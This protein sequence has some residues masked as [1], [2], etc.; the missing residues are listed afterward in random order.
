MLYIVRHFLGEDWQPREVG[1]EAAEVP[2]TVASVL[3]G[4]RIVPAQTAGYMRLPKTGLLAEWDKAGKAEKAASSGALRELDRIELPAMVREIVETYLQDGCPT[5]VETA[6]L[7]GTS[8][9][10][11]KRNLASQGLTYSTLVEQ[12]RFSKA[13]ALLE[14]ADAPMIDIAW[15]LGYSDPSHFSRAF[16][17]MVG[18][19]PSTYRKWLASGALDSRA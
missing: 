7:I 6:A 3:P 1:I 11:L 9:R 4:T 5:L 15:A 8:S 16:R 14:D 18:A 17:R 12:A 13:R 10:T 19:A 2:E